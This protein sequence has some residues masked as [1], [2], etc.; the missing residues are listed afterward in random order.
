MP[1]LAA[2]LILLTLQNQA[3][4]GDC[5]E[6]HECRQM[7]LDAAERGEYERLH[8]L[9]WR[10]VQTGPRNDPALMYLLARAQSLS[11]RPGDALVMLQRL[12]ALG[13]STDAAT[14]DDFRR[15]RSLPGWAEFAGSV[16]ANAG[17]NGD[18]AALK[19]EGARPKAG[20]NAKADLKMGPP[21]K[22]AASEAVRC[23]TLP[24]IAG[25][26]CRLTVTSLGTPSTST[27]TTLPS[28]ALAVPV[29]RTAKV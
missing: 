16:A 24:L 15:V 5:R 23:S 2:A 22:T 26:I 20:A 12:A 17:L 19:A 7:A 11:G 10:A 14:N 29:P 13:V 1:L 6:W 4:R 18:S 3:D 25:P 8:D 27:S 9:A 21:D 28:G